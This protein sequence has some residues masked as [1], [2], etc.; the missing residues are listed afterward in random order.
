[1]AN[2]EHHNIQQAVRGAVQAAFQE[3]LKSVISSV[4]SKGDSKEIELVK[5]EIESTIQS[6][7]KVWAVDTA[8][9]ETANVNEPSTVIDEPANVGDPATECGLLALIDSLRN[10]FPDIKTPTLPELQHI[11]RELGQRFPQFDMDN[12]DTY[13]VDQLAS[14][15][16]AYLE[17]IR[18]PPI[19]LGYIYLTNHGH[20]FAFV[21]IEGNV[22]DVL[23]IHNNNNNNVS[24]EDWK[25]AH[26][27]GISHKGFSYPPEDSTIPSQQD[28]VGQ[29]EESSCEDDA[30]PHEYNSSSDDDERS[31]RG[32]DWQ[33][34]NPIPEKPKKRAH[35]KRQDDDKDEFGRGLS[36][37]E[38]LNLI[39]VAK[40]EYKQQ[41][42]SPTANRKAWESILRASTSKFSSSFQVDV[43]E[44]L[45]DKTKEMIREE[46]DFIYLAAN[47]R[48]ERDGGSELRLTVMVSVPNRK[49]GVLARVFIP[50]SDIT[51]IE[52]ISSDDWNTS[53]QLR[54]SKHLRLC[55]NWMQFKQVYA[56]SFKVESIVEHMLSS[57]IFRHDPQA[58]PTITIQM[59]QLRL[60]AFEDFGALLQAYWSVGR[61]DKLEYFFPNSK[62][63]RLLSKTDIRS[64]EISGYATPMRET[65]LFHTRD[66]RSV[67]IGL[68]EIFEYDI[69]SAVED[70]ILGIPTT[71][72]PIKVPGQ[73]IDGVQC[74]YFFCLRDEECLGRRRL[75]LLQ[76]TTGHAR[77][78]DTPQAASE[79]I[80]AAIQTI[81]NQDMSQQDVIKAEL[82]VSRK[83]D[84]DPADRVNAFKH[85]PLLEA[86]RA[87]KAREQT[88]KADEALYNTY[89]QFS[90]LNQHQQAAILN[91]SDLPYG[92]WLTSGATGTGKTETGLTLLALA[93]LG[94]CNTSTVNPDKC[95]ALI[96]GSQNRQ[97]DDLLGRT[98]SIFERFG[99]KDAVITRLNV[100]PKE[101]DK[102]VNLAETEYQLFELGQ[103]CRG[104]DKL[105]QHWGGDMS[106]CAR[107]KHLIDTS[108]DYEWLA[109]LIK[110]R[111][112]DPRGWEANSQY[113]ETTMYDV[114]SEVS[115]ESDV[116]IC[117]ALAAYSF[118]SRFPEFCTWQVVLTEE[119]ARETEASQYAQWQCA[120]EAILRL[121]TGD[122]K[123]IGPFTV[124]TDITTL[125]ALDMINPSAQ[126][127]MAFLK[128]AA[129][130]GVDVNY[131][132]INMRA[133]GGVERWVST[134]YYAGTMM[135]E[136]Y[137]YGSSSDLV[138]RSIRRILR[139][140]GGPNVKGSSLL[141][142]VDSPGSRHK[143]SGFSPINNGTARVVRE[144][145]RTIFQYGAC[146]IHPDTNSDQVGH[147]AHVLV[148]SPSQAQAELLNQ[149]VTS[150]APIHAHPDLIDVRTVTGAQ[151]H[152]AHIAVY[153]ATRSDG[154]GLSGDRP[155]NVVAASRASH[156]N[157]YIVPKS[158]TRATGEIAAMHA[159]F[160][161]N[162]Q[163]AT[164]YLSN[165][166][167][168]EELTPVGQKRWV[169]K[170]QLSTMAMTMTSEEFEAAQLRLDEAKPLKWLKDAPNSGGWNAKPS[171][172]FD[173]KDITATTTATTD[174]WGVKHSKRS[175]CWER[176]R[177]R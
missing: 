107:V 4:Q 66:H 121:V 40:N 50:F 162:D 128:R 103:K 41:Q 37:E 11:Y 161:G 155:T 52:P 132:D 150:L 177:R 114:M 12:K 26:W 74:G 117:T 49:D 45:C 81:S 47:L 104:Q 48:Y 69:Q 143:K 140:L 55:V 19:Q 96:I 133:H 38:Q 135:A 57:P 15:L 175:N 95:R 3:A 23:W 22:P 63:A 125:P 59:N 176:E 5:S 92:I 89:K 83:P 18:L 165:T 160:K 126:I 167:E 116:I 8:A 30:D 94:G 168:L 44:L 118:H 152:D 91:I 86:I 2:N 169:K 101:K 13:R 39:N 80:R 124:T 43:P 108:E 151:G 87:I 29:V 146:H 163:V 46:D 77:D 62:D 148:M 129:F 20:V 25:Y 147:R 157:I 34:P 73:S 130:A 139:V 53:F 61:I 78:V 21:P 112:S 113:I 164:V 42:Q 65:T 115:M 54:V 171:A 6:L 70:Q 27:S 85:F 31:A 76:V 109:E 172:G 36:A 174:G 35:K 75:Y 144:V 32:I 72:A 136:N 154:L 33:T 105:R 141:L 17:S 79:I 158:A 156:A 7:N 145:V 28:S 173:G 166:L 159:F 56:Y 60:G 58:E 122:I 119:G 51:G 71:W 64:L 67:M 68:S 93:C 84:P 142:L 90:R 127:R 88:A 102:I 98:R 97:C 149:V 106:F 1:M 138:N 110:T 100:F 99:K 16:I 170:D 9:N 111:G 24:D 10:Q 134:R 153:D 14:I 120:P 82:T 137:S 131:L 123:Q